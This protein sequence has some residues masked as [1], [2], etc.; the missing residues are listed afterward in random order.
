M[1]SFKMYV[2]HT[3]HQKRRNLLDHEYQS[4]PTDITV[5]AGSEATQSKS[6]RSHSHTPETPTS[7]MHQFTPAEKHTLRRC[8]FLWAERHSPSPVLA[9]GEL[10]RKVLKRKQ[11]FGTDRFVCPTHRRVQC[12]LSTRLKP[13]ATSRTWEP[14]TLNNRLE[15]NDRLAPQQGCLDR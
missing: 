11:R 2:P 10:R 3:K 8:M 1:H 9:A 13:H 6:C 5:A 12:S 15:I 7:L 4:F 14:V